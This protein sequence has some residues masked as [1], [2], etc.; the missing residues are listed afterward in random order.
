[1]SRRKVEAAKL[2]DEAAAKRRL[3]DAELDAADKLDAQAA[4]L[5]S[6]AENLQIQA[7]LKEAKALTLTNYTDPSALP[8]ADYAKAKSDA[9]IASSA[10][11]QLEQD[12]AKLRQQAQE[13]RQ[14]AAN[15]KQEAAQL[16]QTATAELGSL[17]PAG[18]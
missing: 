13:R 8:N 4:S 3:A 14:K 17:H 7:Q 1:M 16:E 11:E 12:V 6:R 9:S 5:A 15:L 18:R 10:A 2:N